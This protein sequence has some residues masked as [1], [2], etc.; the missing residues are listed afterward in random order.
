[1]GKKGP[2]PGKVIFEKI[3]ACFLNQDLSAT[4]RKDQ[5]RTIIDQIDEKNQQSDFYKAIFE[6]YKYYSYYNEQ[7]KALLPDKI[8]KEIAAEIIAHYFFYLKLEDKENYQRVIRDFAI[9]ESYFVDEAMLSSISSTAVPRMKAVEGR[10]IKNRYLTAEVQGTLKVSIPPGTDIRGAITL[11][12]KGIGMSPAFLG[13]P[14]FRAFPE[15]VNDIISAAPGRRVT[16]VLRLDEGVTWRDVRKNSHLLYS[17][18][19]IESYEIK[20][21]RLEQ[22]VDWAFQDTSEGAIS[23]IEAQRGF[24]IDQIKAEQV[25][26]AAREIL[27]EISHWDE[28]K[29]VC[30]YLKNSFTTNYYAENRYPIPVVEPLGQLGE[31]VKILSEIITKRQIGKTFYYYDGYIGVQPPE[32]LYDYVEVPDYTNASCVDYLDEDDTD[33]FLSCYEAQ[34]QAYAAQVLAGAKFAGSILHLVADVLNPADPKNLIFTAKLVAVIKAA[35]IV[36]KGGIAAAKGYKL[37]NGAAVLGVIYGYKDAR[38]LEKVYDDGKYLRKSFLFI[39][40]E[41]QAHHIIPREALKMT[42]TVQM[43]VLEGF[44]MN[45][46]VE[47]GIK[48]EAYLHVPAIHWSGYNK[49]IMGRILS[50]EASNPGFTR[51]DALH[52]IREE[53]LPEA[54]ATLESTLATL[55]RAKV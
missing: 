49:W 2:L 46:A 20:D 35:P 10:E 53:L 30:Y 26:A 34:R 31:I 40:K 7:T 33:S 28:G 50:F 21:K 14:D 9:E 3:K 11:I 37:I 22:K 8:E 45:K 55:R 15:A 47:N 6:Q 44:N 19:T 39:S 32:N 52:F 1:M 48:I 12:C 23:G 16:L 29:I 42:R 24:K 27:A 5:L 41:Y 13:G 38:R 43:A 18:V 25:N 51:K 54:R 4:Q 17:S 36:V